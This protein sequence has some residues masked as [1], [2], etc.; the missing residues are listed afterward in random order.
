MLVLVEMVQTTGVEAGRAT[1]DP[2][3]L[4]PLVKQQ[5]GPVQDNRVKFPSA[6][7]GEERHAESSGK[8]TYRY[9]PSCP[10]IPIQ[11]PV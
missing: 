8:T 1:N 2:V 11:N 3:H 9:E 5:L 4:V 10:V 6:G 7:V